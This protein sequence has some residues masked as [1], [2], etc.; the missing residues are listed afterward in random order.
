MPQTATSALLHTQLQHAPDTCWQHDEGNSD[1]PQSSHQQVAQL[2]LCQRQASG[3]HTSLLCHL[4]LSDQPHTADKD[5]PFIG[6]KLMQT[7]QYL[8]FQCCYMIRAVAEVC[9]N[10]YGGLCLPTTTP[11][12]LHRSGSW[13]RIH[14]SCSCRVEICTSLEMAGQIFQGIQQTSA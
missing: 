12:P 1:L 9:L 7:T 6:I 14:L 5:V 11:V 13:S 10:M 2:A 4:L 8:K 3:K